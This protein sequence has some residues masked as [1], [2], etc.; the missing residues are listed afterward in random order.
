MANEAGGISLD[1]LDNWWQ[2]RE[3]T[4][5]VTEEA[6]RRIQDNQ[7][8]AQQVGQD[9]KK[10]KAANDKFATFLAF[11]LSDIQS[12]TLIKQFYQT[13]FKTIQQ[14]SEVPQITKSRNITLIV[15]IFVPF[16]EQKIKELHLNE[17]YQDIRPFQDNISLT[18]YIE[19]IK[20]LLL[21]HNN[22]IKINKEAL[23]K[24]L[25][26]LAEYYQLI[27]K[28]PPEKVNEFEH[29]LKKELNINE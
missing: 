2:V 28:L 7:K 17:F 16:Y 5:K 13:F 26:Y 12:D 23:S 25:S 15:G 8:K 29:T 3:D 14:N 11:L 4:N 10:D 20:K 22:N 21:H 18:T 24:L 6:V 1:E 19:Y 27:E 9:I